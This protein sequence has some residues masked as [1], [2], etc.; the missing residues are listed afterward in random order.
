MKQSETPII[1]QGLFST[2]N[3]ELLKVIPLVE[4]P[5]KMVDELPCINDSFEKSKIQPLNKAISNANE[6]PTMENMREVSMKVYEILGY[7]QKAF[8]LDHI[9]DFAMAT[10]VKKASEGKDDITKY[11][12]TIYDKDG[13]WF[14]SDEKAPSRLDILLNT[15]DTRNFQKS[16]GKSLSRIIAKLNE[17]VGFNEKMIEQRNIDHEKGQ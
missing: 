17:T 9:E 5:Q 2:E 13:K 14:A 11:Y 15:T 1:P 4:L 10:S 6:N 12:T 3:D 7:V 16:Y 8:G